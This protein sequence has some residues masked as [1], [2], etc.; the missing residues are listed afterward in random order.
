MAKP[1]GYMEMMEE[2]KENAEQMEDFECVLLLKAIYGL[3][4]AARQFWK[5]F[6]EAVAKIGFKPNDSDPCLLYREDNL[7]PCALIMYIDDMLIIGS[8]EA[9]DD[10]VKGIKSYF[11]IT[12]AADLHDYLGIQ[13]VKSKD[14]KKLWL[15]QPTIIKSLKDKFGEQAM[16]SRLTLTPGT[17]GYVGVKALDESCLMSPEEQS[18]FRSGV[19]TLL[20][21]T[22][23]SRPDITNAVRELSKTMD[24]AT[25][26][27]WN[28]MWRVIKFVLMTS[29]LGLR[30]CPVVIDPNNQ[31]WR[32]KALSDS[33]FSNDVD[34]RISVYGYIV[35]YCGVPVSWKGKG[36]KSVVLSTT[37]AEYIAVSEVVKEISFLIQLLQGMNIKVDLPVKVHVDNVGAIW[38]AN[39][40]NTSERTKHVDIRAHF[41]R[42]FIVDGRIEIVFVKSK[43]NDSDIFT[44]NLKSELYEIHK[45]KIVWTIAD[46]N[47]EPN[48]KWTFN[49]SNQGNN[50]N[51]QNEEE[52]G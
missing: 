7:G 31:V 20:Y 26:C 10:A 1:Q 6:T 28:E 48:P 39:N 3:V 14:G 27:Q 18:I 8:D 37:E 41:V 29:E 9:I 30:M 46:M 52:N 40:R 12:E 4:Q 35:Y 5:T 36:M 49:N 13:I 19:G 17:P 2:D 38:L 34:T 50:Y 11:N 33:D 15:G 44:K 25:K 21:L 24:G 32:L 23:H 45:K 16:R 43:D 42:E 51:S 22:K 47:G